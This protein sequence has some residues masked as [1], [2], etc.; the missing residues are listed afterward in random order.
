VTLCGAR[1]RS[2]LVRVATGDKSVAATGRFPLQMTSRVMG[3]LE[4]MAV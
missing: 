3:L 2:A 4:I 1:E